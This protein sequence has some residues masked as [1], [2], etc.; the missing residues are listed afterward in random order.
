[1]GVLRMS[2]DAAALT[3]SPPLSVT[4]QGEVLDAPKLDGAAMP[5]SGLRNLRPERREHVLSETT[6]GRRSPGRRVLR[7][8]GRFL[9]AVLLGICGTLGWQAYG[10]EAT[11][12][13]KS[14]VSTHASSLALL[15]SATKSN[16]PHLEA[17]EQRLEPA[18][19][20]PSVQ[21]DPKPLAGIDAT[22]LQRQLAPITADLASTKKTIEQISA[23]QHQLT[24]TQQQFAQN[25]VELQT[26]ERG[27]SQKLSS[28][29]SPVAAVP[30]PKAKPA[31]NAP[32][33]LSHGLPN[34]MRTLP[35][36][37]Q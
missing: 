30:V 28:V 13:L 23:S 6:S 26:L 33:R 18:I 7:T 24:Q 8:C 36:P 37:I 25:I 34:S 20:D 2:M 1:M 29:A 14:Q 19:S 4:A 17:T 21:Q 32:Q 9:F 3:S 27:L 16:S 15:W 5:H 10:D 11:R 22:E 35:P 12:I 31:Q